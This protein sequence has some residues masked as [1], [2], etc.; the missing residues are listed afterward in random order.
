MLM[1]MARYR[2]A[3]IEIA[4]E[5]ELSL[6]SDD[7]DALRS[8]LARAGI[9][10]WKLWEHENRESIAEF[11]RAEPVGRQRNTDWHDPVVWRWLT[12]GALQQANL[13]VV[14]LDAR[15]QLHPGGSWQ[16]TCVEA[17]ELGQRIVDVAFWFW[18]FELPGP[19]GF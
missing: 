7:V 10:E 9:S 13:A 2:S 1:S 6:S 5:L 19:F 3:C 17:A 11:L 4:Q 8:E 18:P 15:E 16:D 14:V 12:L